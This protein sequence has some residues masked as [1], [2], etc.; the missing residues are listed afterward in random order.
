MIIS[1]LQNLLLQVVGTI[2]KK[3][4][5]STLGVPLAVLVILTGLGVYGA[6]AG[7]ARV[8]NTNQDTAY[9]VAVDE[10]FS[11]TLYIERVR[12]FSSNEK[13]HLLASWMAAFHGY[14]YLTSKVFSWL[15]GFCHLCHHTRLES[16]IYTIILSLMHIS[17]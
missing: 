7:A 10:S 9:S 12:T 3:N 5:Y 14:Q 17:I 8:T 15:E 4:P 1:P 11:F 16:Y 13:L 6:L 2:V